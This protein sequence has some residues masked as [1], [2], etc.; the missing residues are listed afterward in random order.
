MNTCTYTLNVN[1][2]EMKKNDHIFVCTF[3]SIDDD[4]VYSFMLERYIH[5]FYYIK[6]SLRFCIIYDM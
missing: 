6:D 1:E 2:N 4:N 3:F 5:L